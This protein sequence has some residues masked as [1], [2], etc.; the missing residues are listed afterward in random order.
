[1]GTLCRVPDPPATGTRRAD[2]AACRGMKFMSDDLPEQ[3][4]AKLKWE[5]EKLTR[6]GRSNA[7][8]QKVIKERTRK[9]RG[10]P[11]SP[12]D[13]HVERIRARGN[14]SRRSEAIKIA[15]EIGDGYRKSDSISD[16]IKLKSRKAEQM[17]RYRNLIK[18][19]SDLIV[20][21]PLA[22]QE[23]Y[24]NHLD[25]QAL[26][27]VAGDVIGQLPP[28][29][30]D[31]DRAKFHLTEAHKAGIRHSPSEDTLSAVEQIIRELRSRVGR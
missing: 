22:D 4:R 23:E 13:D 11:P 3:R 9:P 6:Q 15:D 5:I 20:L 19:L 25:H 2:A 27:D 26:L 30:E 18:E 8:I 24:I 17:T 10:R 28:G 7:E 1:V 14:K 12:D 31:L 16:R 21:L 29:S